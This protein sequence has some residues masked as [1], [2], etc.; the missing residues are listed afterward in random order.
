MHPF[1]KMM[2]VCITRE[3]TPPQINPGDIIVYRSAGSDLLNVHRVLSKNEKEGHFLVK[4]DNV[5]YSR[6][7][8]VTSAGIREKVR[9]VKRGEKVFN[10]ERF[11]SKYT[12]G[13]LAFLSRRDLM[14]TLFK[15][16]FIDPILLGVSASPFFA[17]IRKMFYADISFMKKKEGEACRVYA[18]AGK[19]RSAEA[20]LHLKESKGVFISSYI[21]YRDRNPSFAEKFMKKIVDISDSEYGSQHNIYITDNVLSGLIQ[22]GK[23]LSLGSRIRL[24]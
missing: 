12:A 7:E 22:R 11:P 19:G 24:P 5:P 1:L 3:I 9:L 17:S 14:P 23:G 16:K 20:I 15:R 21:R 13:L 8:R 2:D 6:H 18:F 4:G 10:L